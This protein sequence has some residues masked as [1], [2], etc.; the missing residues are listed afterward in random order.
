[1]VNGYDQRYLL[2]HSP[3]GII[4]STHARLCGKM[5]DCMCGYVTM[6]MMLNSSWFLRKRD[7]LRNGREDCLE[8]IASQMFSSLPSANFKSVRYQNH[9]NEQE[10][11][12]SYFKMVKMEGSIVKNI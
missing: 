3:S 9:A 7:T 8:T 11:L 6:G 1:M 5:L 2:K 10:K 4:T 12:T